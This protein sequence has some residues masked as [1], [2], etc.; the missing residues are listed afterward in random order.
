MV[1]ESESLRKWEVIVGEAVEEDMNVHTYQL[2]SFTLGSL[3]DVLD[4]SYMAIHPLKGKERNHSRTMD[5]REAEDVTLRTF[6][7]ECRFFLS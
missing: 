3:A 5:V 6:M 4:I 7:A 2:Q 1:T